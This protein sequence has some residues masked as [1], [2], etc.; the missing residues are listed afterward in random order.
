MRSSRGKILFVH[1]LFVEFI[2][3]SIFV[4]WNF[5]KANN[6]TLLDCKTNRS[7]KVHLATVY[8]WTSTNFISLLYLK[9]CQFVVQ[10]WLTKL[11]LSHFDREPLD[12]GSNTNSLKLTYPLKISHP[13]KIPKEMHLPTIDFQGV[14]SL[15]PGG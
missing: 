7:T 11:V 14:N 10:N 3:Y 6:I 12:H 2:V 9:F 8:S 4:H 15:F 13:K 5:S 1:T